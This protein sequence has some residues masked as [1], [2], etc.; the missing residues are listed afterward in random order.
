MT[1][2][3]GPV[4]RLRN[5]AILLT[6]CLASCGDGGGT[7]AST[8][9]A[10]AA[11]SSTSPSS[12]P[13]NPIV[14]INTAVAGATIAA[15]AI[16]T[17]MAIWY[18]FTQ[19]GVTAQTE[20]LGAHMVRWPG[21]SGSDQYHWQTGTGCNGQYVA[22][23]TSFDNF[24]ADI[25]KPAKLDVAITLNYGSNATCTGGADPNE[26]AA[27][28]AHAKALGLTGLHWT[29]GNEVYGSWEYDLHAK[30]HDPATYAGAVAGASGY[31][32]L[33][34]AQDSTAN[35]GVVVT[36]NNTTWDAIVLANAPYDFVELHYYAQNPGNENDTNL[37][38]QG[39]AQ[40]TALIKSVQSALATAGKP[41]TPIYLGEFNS[42]SSNP[43]KQSVSIVNGLYAG[44]ALGEVLNAGLPMATWWQGIGAGCSTGGNN[45]T[46]LY[47]WQNFGSYGQMADTWP[48]PYG[49]A[50]APSIPQGTLM[51]SGQAMALV[52]QF[53]IAGN[54]MLPIAI[55]STLPLV[56]GYAATQ[57]SGYSVLLVNLDQNN[58]ATVTLQLQGA[59]QT[60]FSVSTISYGKAQYDTSQ[61]NVWTPP[62][63][64]ALGNTNATPS[65]TLPAWSLTVVQLK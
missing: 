52:S 55:P 25:V 50:G 32:Q 63:T 27:W 40:L 38:T 31:Y 26:A 17:N 3:L 35:V 5:S 53:A 8:P 62:V 28:V 29:V 57:G 34:K 21:G 12:G 44:M 41:N 47:G 2:K 30:P 56:R 64:S 54:H 7:S 48:N 65:I 51:P 15:D 20:A 46:S 22:P 39:P 60:Q 13:T 36:G 9:N 61:S 37:L 6:S 42:V 19:P 4:A 18:D 11:T 33:I 14:T 16:G 59:T 45:A 10:P 58:P 1:T 24:V 49:C 23:N 43:G